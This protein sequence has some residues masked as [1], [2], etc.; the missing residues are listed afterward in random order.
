MHTYVRHRRIA[1]ALLCGVSFLL[2]AWGAL[3]TVVGQ[4]LDNLTME[5]LV[6]RVA[7]LPEHLDLATSLVSVPILATVSVLVALVALL[8]RRPALALRAVAVVAGANLT[9]QVVKAVLDRPDLG[10]S[11]NLQ[12][13]FPS[14]HTTFAASIAA[15]L[16][17]VAPRGFRSGA[18]L[19]GWAWTAV[20][21]V[22]VI[23]QGWHRLSDVLGAILLVAVWG[24]LAAPVEERDRVMPHLVT[25]MIGVAWVAMLAG[26]AALVAGTALVAADLSA[27]LSLLEIRDLIRSGSGA[28][29]WF[30]LAALALPTGLAGVLTGSLNWFSGRF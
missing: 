28:G 19:F 6:G 22:V 3:F 7:L 24:L 14:G 29:M 1:G 30:T 21:G 12:N 23:S 18:A 9:T 27:P 13:S 16:I 10:V 26:V 15:A 4:N 25:A 8:R 20:M 17:L 2:L 11:L 5:A